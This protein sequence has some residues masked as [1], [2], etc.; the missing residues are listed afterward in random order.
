MK[1]L[2]D[3]QRARFWW[4]FTHWWI[5]KD[6]IS[7]LLNDKETKWLASHTYCS[8]ISWN[9]KKN[10]PHCLD[11]IVDCRNNAWPFCCKYEQ[12][13]KSEILCHCFPS[14]RIPALRVVY[15]HTRISVQE[16]GFQLQP[17]CTGQPCLHCLPPLHED[18][19]CRLTSCTS[20]SSGKTKQYLS[21]DHCRL[22]TKSS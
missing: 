4:K 18:S 20:C 12:F 3:S 19:G 9:E 16:V 7:S 10:L 8:T 6:F 13:W 1:Q 14:F 11:C 22:L 21:I 2:K 5:A 15:K 17:P